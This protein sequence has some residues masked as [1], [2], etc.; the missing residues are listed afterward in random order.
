MS[1]PFDDPAASYQVIV[2]EDGQHSLWPTSIEIPNGWIIV[3]DADSRGRC[4][5][6]IEKNWT[7]MRPLSLINGTGKRF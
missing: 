4:I 2:N 5:E 3:H 6:F 7:D 1:N